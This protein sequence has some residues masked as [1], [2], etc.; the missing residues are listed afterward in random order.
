M[1]ARRVQAATSTA[2]LGFTEAGIEAV[3]PRVVGGAIG[4]AGSSESLA[5]LNRA[6]SELKAVAVEPILHQALAALQKEDHAEGARWALMALEQDERCGFAWYL[7]AIARE[8]AG[9]FASSV[10][11]YQSA[12]ELMPDHAE[13]TNHM[14]RLAYR[15]GMKT[16]AEKLFAHFM[17]RFPDNHEGANN[18]ACTVRDQGRFEDAIEILRPAIMANP[19][20]AMLWNT[21]GTV[22][23]EQGEFDTAVTF[24]D[25]A[26]RLDPKLAKARYNRGNS[27]LAVGDALGALADCEAAMPDAVA[28]EDLTMMQLARSTILINLGRIGEGWDA[29]EARLHPEFSGVTG[30]IMDKPRWTLDDDLAGRSLL[31][32]GEQGL[33]DEILFAQMLP[34]VLEAL[35]P[36]GRLTFAVEPR[37]VS[38]FQRSFPHIQVGAHASYNHQGRLARA[39]PF[40]DDAAPVDLWTPIGSLLRRFR[41]DVTSFGCKPGF[42]A[43][44]PARV[45]HWRDVLERE[46]PKG[47][48]I[49]L[50]WKSIRLEG[51]RLRYYSPFEHW[52]P[53]LA[54]PG[55]VF[56]NMQY[57][58][59]AAEIAEAKARLSVDI[60]QPPAIDLKQDL[61]DVAALS[62]ALDLIIGPANA[63]SNIAAACGAPLWLI[64]TPGAWP[65]LG[66]DRYPWYPQARVFLPP[67][68]NQWPQ[69]MAEV[70]QALAETFP[71]TARSP[72]RKVSHRV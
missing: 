9:D 27:R 26:L 42:L 16:V 35:G 33:G 13:L 46:A 72:E 55:A 14:G 19:G 34:D 24:F 56:V 45:R 32:F 49:G 25:E 44:A 54:T 10:T 63:T 1:P 68:F 38:L 61:D 65:R 21:M 36:E 29:Y 60:W 3:R 66:T 17:A 70:S 50:L 15:M 40:I 28:G 8:K 57:G 69:V 41:R 39:A 4:D 47:P 62:C 48:K 52:A 12:L 2:A 71:Q 30:Y 7:L 31:V 59:C 20:I 67:T 53:V 5:R 37:L 43:A 64:S 11:C 22:V 18:Y 23:A 51:A 58:D 6:M